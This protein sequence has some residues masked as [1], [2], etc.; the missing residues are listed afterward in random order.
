MHCL[1]L[2]CSFFI[3]ICRSRKCERLCPSG[4]YG[5]NCSQTCRCKNNA[6]CSR[7]DGTCNCTQRGWTG[8]LCHLPCPGGYYGV[9][10]DNKCKC[11]NGAAC[12]RETG[13]CRKMFLSPHAFAH[14]FILHRFTRSF[15]FLTH[16]LACLLAYLFTHPPAQLRN[17][18]LELSTNFF[19]VRLFIVAFSF[20]FSRFLHLHQ[21]LDWSV[22]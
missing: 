17:H 1:F 3:C 19:P 21:W 4:T 8:V 2:E 13:L 11:Q 22:L 16:L 12:D 7:Q 18:L 15:H 10:C 20:S 14:F 5:Y 6:T 9:N